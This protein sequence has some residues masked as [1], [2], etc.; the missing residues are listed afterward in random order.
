MEE[1]LFVAKPIRQLIW[2]HCSRY[3]VLSNGQQYTHLLSSIHL[4]KMIVG[5]K[6]LKEH[7]EKRY[8]DINKTLIEFEK[9]TNHI[10][11][12]CSIVQK[13]D[14]RSTS[15]YD[16]RFRDYYNALQKLPIIHQEILEVFVFLISQT[17]LIN[18]TIPSSYIA[19]ASEEMTFETEEDQRRD[20]IFQQKDKYG[21]NQYEED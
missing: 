11:A 16:S 2:K 17:T 18:S 5:E 15:F 1:K 3:A 12:F 6:I 9:L 10:N 14:Y 20:K 19:Q 13:K 8:G 21:L 4:L 7:F